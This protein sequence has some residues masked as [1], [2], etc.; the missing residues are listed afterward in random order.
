LALPQASH[1]GLAN[2]LEL[3]ADNLAWLAV[4]LRRDAADTLAEL[5]ERLDY[6]AYLVDSSGFPHTGEGRAASVEALADYARDKGSLLAFVQHL[7]QLARENIG[8]VRCEDEDAV[9][10]STIHGAKGLECPIVS[11]LSVTRTS[12]PFRGSA[13]K[14]WKKKGDYSTLR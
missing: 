9:T 1:D 6:K 11:W 10:L 8:R 14:T 13:P 12:C 4:R 3:L 2:N 5:E 7:H